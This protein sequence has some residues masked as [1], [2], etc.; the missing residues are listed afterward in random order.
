MRAFLIRWLPDHGYTAP[1]EVVCEKCAREFEHE[2]AGQC[3]VTGQ[4]CKSTTCGVC[5]EPMEV[6]S[7]PTERQLA[8]YYNGPEA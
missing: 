2:T 5:M 8:R 3:E 4:E 6:Y 7:E 1:P